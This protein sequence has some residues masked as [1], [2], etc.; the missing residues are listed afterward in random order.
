MT[1]INPN[2]AENTNQNKGQT[3]LLC[4]CSFCSMFSTLLCSHLSSTKRTKHNSHTHTEGTQND[5]QYHHH[6]HHQPTVPAC[7]L[8]SF[9]F[10]PLLPFRLTKLAYSVERNQ[11]EMYGLHT[12]SAVQCAVCV[13]VPSTLHSNGENHA[14]HTQALGL[15]EFGK[16]SHFPNQE[17]ANKKNKKE[18]TQHQL[19]SP[20]P[21]R[22]SCWLAAA[23]RL[24]VA[25]V[26]LSRRSYVMNPSHSR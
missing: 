8:S 11:G 21:P 13:K 1:S 4:C 12:A 17:Q 20:P 24:T 26:N 23:I 25:W 7:L 14:C 9:F 5:D 22:M 16:S 3:R 6:L 19:P 2:K 18:R 15:S 10:L